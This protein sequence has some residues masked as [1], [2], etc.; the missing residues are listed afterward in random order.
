MNGSRKCSGQ[1]VLARALCLFAIPQLQAVAPRPPLWRQPAA[2]LAFLWLVGVTGAA[3]LAP[4]LAPKGPVVAEPARALLPPGPGGALGTDA[5]GRDMLV[6]LLWGGRWTLTMAAV[7]LALS[8]ALGLPW[9]LLAGSRGGAVDAVLMRLLDAWLAFPDL[10]LA[11]T[12]VA[13]LGPGLLSAAIGVGLSAAAS[14]ARVARTT[15]RAIRTQPYIEAARALGA[16]PWRIAIRHI[17]PNA[18]P[19]LIAFSLAQFGR[20]LLSGASLNFLGLG[21]PPGTPDWA[22]MLDEGR[23]YFRVAPWMATFPG[24]ALTLTVL[25]ANL[26]GDRVQR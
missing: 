15:A 14:Y 26:L 19:T 13:I 12:V 18:A 9:G 4:Y 16:S 8:I 25:A 2:I 17:L 22:A 5:L 23:S 1:H 7:A 3:I 20:I 10:L 6:R 21:A 24:L 11:M